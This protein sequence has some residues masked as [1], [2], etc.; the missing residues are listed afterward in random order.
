MPGTRG[1]PWLGPLAVSSAE[2]GT[3]LRKPQDPLPQALKTQQSIILLAVTILLVVGAVIALGGSGDV[4]AVSAVEESSAPIEEPAETEEPREMDFAPAISLSSE[5]VGEPKAYIPPGPPPTSGSVYGRLSVATD[6]IGEFGTY[7]ILVNELINPNSHLVDRKPFNLRKSF[8]TDLHRTPRFAITDIPFS[9]YGYDV[10]VFVVDFNGS[11]RT[12]HL[13]PD[14]PVAGTPDHAESIGE[15]VI[16]SVS[17]GVPFSLRL[18]DQHYNPVVRQLVDL[19]PV[20]EP[21][22]RRVYSGETD[23]FGSCIYENVI[24]GQYDVRVG[25]SQT[26]LERVTVVSAGQSE[27]Q[28]AQILVPTGNDLQIEVSSKIGY[29]IE[30]AELL[31]YAVDTTENRRHQAVTDYSGIYVFPHLMPGTYQLDISASGFQR[32]TRKIRITDEGM[33]KPVQV[34]LSNR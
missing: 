21:I 1:F 22:G 7:T 18:R 25:A 6:A 13:T 19:I 4:Q 3:I 34:R 30:G 24:R 28:A 16:L 11:K 29:G 17:L 15:E 23:G 8:K 2:R 26:I 5:K 10:E 27:L 20:G 9:K 33:Q 14:H 12:I 32:T 31:L